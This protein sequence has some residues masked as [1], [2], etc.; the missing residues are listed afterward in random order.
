VTT[1]LKEL[2]LDYLE[3]REKFGIVLQK[4]KELGT[5]KKG[6]VDDEEFIAI[7]EEVCGA[8]AARS[9]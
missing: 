3:D 5:S 8:A 7:V 9:K 1:K 4:I 6:L 2:G